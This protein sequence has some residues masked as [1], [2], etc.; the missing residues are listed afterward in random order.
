[1]ADV[2]FGNGQ[3][4]VQLVFQF[5]SRFDEFDSDSDADISNAIRQA[6]MFVDPAIW[7]PKDYAAAILNLAAHFQSLK[8][9]QLASTELGGTGETDIYVR[10]IHMDDRSVAFN[11]RSSQQQVESLSGPG[12]ALLSQTIYGMVYLMLRARN[13]S[14]VAVV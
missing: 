9:M 2:T 3:T 11:Q 12:E 10:S 6:S 4:L 7:N 8:D 14:A 1:M 5:R 13:I